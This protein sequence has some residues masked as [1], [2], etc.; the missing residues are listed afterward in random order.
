[1]AIVGT[2]RIVASRI[3]GVSPHDPTTLIGVAV[4]L[5]L[6]ELAVCY[7]PARRATIVDPMND[8]QV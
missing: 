3:C 8:L 7:L 1:M 4:V 6:V 5:V 2:T